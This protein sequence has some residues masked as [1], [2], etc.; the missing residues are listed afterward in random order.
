MWICVGASV[1]SRESALGFSCDSFAAVTVV[2]GGQ[3]TGLWYL[4]KTFS[5]Q[6]LDFK[7]KYILLEN[8]KNVVVTFCREDAKECDGAPLLD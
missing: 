4:A 6:Q 5:T 8:I 7:C 1:G 3:T 2:T